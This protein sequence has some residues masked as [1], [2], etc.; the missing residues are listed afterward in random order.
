MSNIYGFIQGALNG[1]NS[2]IQYSQDKDGNIWGS[3]PEVKV[4][5]KKEDSG[6]GNKVNWNNVITGATNALPG[7]LSGI[8]AIK[9]NFGSPAQN[10]PYWEPQYTGQTNQNLLLIAAFLIGL[11]LLYFFIKKVG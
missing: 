8:A 11:M 4:T 1:A 7:I 10:G 3:I 5:S 6:G 9:G 2:G